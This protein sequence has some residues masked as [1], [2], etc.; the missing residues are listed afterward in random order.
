MRYLPT[1][2]YQG[3]RQFEATILIGSSPTS[4]VQTLN[5]FGLETETHFKDV[6]SS[7][8]G[9]CQGA[10]LGSPLEGE[11]EVN[12][13]FGPRKNTKT[14]KMEPHRGV[15]LKA[16]VGDSVLAAADGFVESISPVSQ[17]DQKTGKGWGYYV[18]IRH[19]DHSKTLYAHLVKDSYTVKAKDK[20]NPRKMGI[21][22]SPF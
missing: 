19:A 10:T 11:L 16:A 14:G 17:L 7:S 6:D 22:P 3:N 15:D 1:Q 12:S 2:A 13:P 9:S 21:A 4:R 18:I 5:A 8:G 20:D